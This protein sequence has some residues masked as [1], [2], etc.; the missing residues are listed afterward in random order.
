[1]DTDEN[2]HQDEPNAKKRKSKAEREVYYEVD[3]E[4]RSQFSSDS[5]VKDP[6]QPPP[7]SWDA[8]GQQQNTGPADVLNVERARVGGGRGG[9]FP[10]YI[11]RAFGTA[12]GRQG[13]GPEGH[14]PPD[15]PADD[16]ENPENT[17]PPLRS[18]GSRTPTVVLRSKAAVEISNHQLYPRS[19]K[20][21]VD[22]IPLHVKSFFNH[23]D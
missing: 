18:E 7:I 15:A 17:S 4:F 8:P 23:S 22:P 2:M 13:T 14:V 1:M 11:N 10:S 3:E 20:A 19:W 6:M 5:D 9:A 21:F 12:D 16:A